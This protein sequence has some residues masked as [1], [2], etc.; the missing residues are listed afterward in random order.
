MWLCGL[1]VFCI[2]INPFSLDSEKSTIDHF[3]VVCSV[4]RLLNKSEAG[5]DLSLIQT[6]LLF[7]CK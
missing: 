6:S 4:T 3:T 5:V 1:L 2:C 7:F